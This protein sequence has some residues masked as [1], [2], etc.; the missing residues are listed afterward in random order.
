MIK[1]YLGMHRRL[2]LAFFLMSAVAVWVIRLYQLPVQAV[3]YT[4]AVSGFFGALFLLD[5][6]WRYRKRLLALQA[7]QKEILVSL[8]CLPEP[9]N[10]L[11]EQYQELLRAEFA[12]KERLSADQRQRFEEMMEYYGMW[13]HQI[14]TPIAAA[15][16]IL[17]SASQQ[18][19]GALSRKDC[20][21]L[22]EE[23]RR[24]RQYVE[25]VLCY[26]RLDSD[27]TDYVI[28]EYELDPMIRKA[29]REQ[30]SVFIRKKISLHYE[31]LQVKVLTDEKWLLFVIEQVLSNALK[32]TSSGSI[33][34]SM[35]KPKTLCIR[36]TGIGIAPEDLPRIF[37]KGY[38]GSNGRID[39]Q[40]SGIGLYLCRRICEKLGHTITA[41]S[42]SDGTELRINLE[43]VQLE[44][45]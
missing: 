1:S 3:G 33:T 42:D 45:E 38:T 12:E 7:L 11:E 22:Q 13:V 40:A 6:F 14:K 15:Q 20:G 36:D 21:D 9:V 43:S 39:R 41:V 8:D 23:M 26:L 31:P 27:S 16:L 37:E 44:I 32:Y 24:I 30:A 28:R 19:T 2:I 18:E 5:D 29:V 4:V 34:I 10:R 17:Q 25:M 35:K